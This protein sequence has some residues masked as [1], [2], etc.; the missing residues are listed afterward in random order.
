[1][2]NNNDK[3]VVS[4]LIMPNNWDEHGRFTGIALYTNDEEGCTMEN[5]SLTEE[6]KNWMHQHVEITREI[7]RLAD[8]RKTFDADNYWP[9]KGDLS[10]E[11]RK[12]KE[13]AMPSY[14][15]L[16][17][18]C[19]KQFSLRQSLADYENKKYACPGCKTRKI[20]QQITTFQTKTSRKS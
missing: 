20:K 5:D 19:N 12:R 10:D 6:L 4:G 16:C 3:M 15:F 17:E 18:K 2:K 14:E 9:L 7:R 1:M 8:G 13:E 11:M